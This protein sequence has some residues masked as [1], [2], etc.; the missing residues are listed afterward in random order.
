MRHATYFLKIHERFEPDHPARFFSDKSQIFN[1]LRNLI[2]EFAGVGVA[3]EKSELRDS[4]GLCFK[5][6]L[7]RV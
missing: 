2:F 1:E 3:I 4:S 7:G 5:I 6:F